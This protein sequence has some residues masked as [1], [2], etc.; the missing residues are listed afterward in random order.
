MIP[1]PPEA[2]AITYKR[3][4]ENLSI[5]ESSIDIPTDLPRYKVDTS[6]YDMLMGGD[7]W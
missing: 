1:C 7:Y 2:V 4:K 5:Y 6:Q 3:L